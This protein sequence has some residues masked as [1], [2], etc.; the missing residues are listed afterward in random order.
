MITGSRPPGASHFARPFHR[1]LCAL[2]AAT[3]LGLLP[4]AA[5]ADV[6]SYPVFIELE[7][8]VTG[9][10]DE[11]VEETYFLTGTGRVDYSE[12][13]LPG[14]PFLIQDFT[15]VS[16]IAA[17]AGGVS[18]SGRT[19]FRFDPSIFPNLPFSALDLESPLGHFA[20]TSRV[21]DIGLADPAFILP[22]G[23]YGSSE[24][25]H[26]EGPEGRWEVWF[27]G[28]ATAIP[29]PGVAFTLLAG[30]LILAFGRSRAA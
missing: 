26:F 2:L 22:F 16:F 27:A 20:F 29:E 5:R 30:S 3:S 10:L 4:A 19:S 11:R 7:V 9:W 28:T 15:A 8:R 23:G 12:N 14:Y 6:I 25:P 24:G 13:F 1:L 21:G 18:A 17:D